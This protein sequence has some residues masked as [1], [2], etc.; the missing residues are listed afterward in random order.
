VLQAI[1]VIRGD[2]DVGVQAEPLDSGATTAGDGRRG[3]GSRPDAQRPRPAPRSGCRDAGHR[4][5]GESREHGLGARQRGALVVAARV[6]HSRDLP[7]DLLGHRG[8]VLVRRRRHRVEHRRTTRGEPIHADEGTQHDAG[9][10]RVERHAEPEAERN[11]QHPL[12]HGH[13]RHHVIAEVRGEVGHAAA[14]ARQAEAAALA[15]ERDEAALPATVA[16]DPDEPV[17]QNPA[18]EERLDFID[19]EA[20]EAALAAVLPFGRGQERPPVLGE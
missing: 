9:E 7:V 1:A 8:H 19:H 17:S 15:G 2:A 20:R 3:G 11:G 12:P 5:V 10:R 6:Q 13:V 14:E 16:G 18:L 4:G